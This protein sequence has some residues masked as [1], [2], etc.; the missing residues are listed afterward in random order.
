M[1][2]KQSKIYTRGEFVYIDATIKDL[3][4]IRFS[5][6]LKNTKEN[7]ARVVLNIKDYVFEYLRCDESKKTPK[8]SILALSEV[9][10]QERCGHLKIQSLYKYKSN[11]A[12][13]ARFFGDRDIRLL[14]QKEIN[15]Y[16]KQSKQSYKIHFLN[17]LIEFSR[18]E[19]IITHLKPL[20][21][22]F[23]RQEQT[24]NILPFTL[25]EVQKI[26]KHT[27]G[28]LK[29]YLIIAFFTGMRTGEILALKWG[30]IDFKC[31]KIYVGKSRE[32]RGQITTT[33]TKQVRYVDM[34]DIVS[35]YLSKRATKGDDFI[36]TYNHIT[37]RKQWYSLLTHLGFK[38][39]A[40]YQ[41]RHSFATIM[42]THKEE[43][44]W[45]SAMLGHKSLSTTFAHY[46]KYIPTHIQRATFLKNM[47]YM[48][49]DL[50]GE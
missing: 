7:V 32:Q 1:E 37:L 28:E 36:F 24:E 27:Q 41:T 13:L 6:K 16:A 25:Q 33:K 2:I 30:D 12:S 17:R 4:R 22:R 49:D 40:I 34:L 38:Q 47:F 19:G 43:V 48:Q 29:L 42:L 50:K 3:G 44:L 45:I 11:I 23:E 18:D 31:K 21:I 15:E 9:F 26:L 14:S 39:R 8:Y 20:K 35:E 46:V 10:L 5:T